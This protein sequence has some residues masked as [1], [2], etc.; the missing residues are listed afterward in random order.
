M[1]MG[2]LELHS[3][4]WY[5]ALAISIPQAILVIYIGFSFCNVHVGFT[6]CMI[7]SIIFA[8]STYFIRRISIP[9]S[10]N[11][12]ILTATLVIVTS[13]VLRIHIG[14]TLIA[15]LL[16]VMVSGVIESVVIQTF[17]HL[18]NHAADELLVDAVLNLTAYMPVFLVTLIVFGLIKRFNFVVF[19]LK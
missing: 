6:Q 19:D 8:L 17:L 10:L 2:V 9:L 4:P 13:A 15:V 7:C 1:K 3:I 18:T 11:T 5:L 16:G 14:K 12:L